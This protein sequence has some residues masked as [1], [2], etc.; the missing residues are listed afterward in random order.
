MIIWL[1][2]LIFKSLLN[3]SGHAYLMSTLQEYIEI[4]SKEFAKEWWVLQPIQ[5]ASVHPSKVDQLAH[6]IK[7][8]KEEWS[9]LQSQP[10]CDRGRDRHQSGR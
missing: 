4:K 8:W 9:R 7:Q 6:L 3:V 2:N 1:E 10:S 5:T